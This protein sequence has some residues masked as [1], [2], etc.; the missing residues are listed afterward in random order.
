MISAVNNLTLRGIYE[1][2]LEVFTSREKILDWGPRAAS[3]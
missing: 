3:L 2:Y 1:E